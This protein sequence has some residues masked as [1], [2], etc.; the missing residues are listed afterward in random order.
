[1]N[2]RTLFSFVSDA[3]SAIQFFQEYEIIHNPR[4][5]HNGHD[6]VLN[7]IGR[8]RWVCKKRTCRSEKQ[9]RNDTWLT[10]SKLS[11]PK[12]VHFIYCWANQ[13]TSIAFCE[14]ELEMSHNAIVDWNNYLREVCANSLL[15]NPTTIGGVND[16]VEIDESLF[17]RRKH[18]KG[19][20]VSEQWVFGGISR[21]TNE[22]F[23]IA[24]PNRAA[25]TLVPIIETYIKPGTTIMS[26]EWKAYDK[27]GEVGYNHLT[28]NHSLNFVDPLSGAHTQRVENMW[29]NA[30]MR[31]KK[32]C[33]TA[34]SMIDSYL[35]E[36]MWRQRHKN[37]DM[38]KCILRDINLFWPPK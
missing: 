21:N 17:V 9:V 27:L 22:C 34:Q 31:N 14:K 23:L 16:F 11:L 35:C 36:F 5:C 13:Y 20:Q 26:D 10:G 15:E 8:E 7:L 30:K 25:A 6:M 32:H 24:V 38:F 19:R 2:L 33:G 1:M 3:S 4:K 12:I 37:V 18:N 28:V 29:K